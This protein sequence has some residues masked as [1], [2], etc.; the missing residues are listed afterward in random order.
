MIGLFGAGAVPAAASGAASLLAALAVALSWRAIEMRLLRRIYGAPELFQLLATF[1]VMLI[2]QDAALWIWGP[3]DLLG[4]R[5]PGTCG[6]HRILGSRFPSTTCCSSRSGQRARR[7]VWLAAD[8]TRWGV[9]VRAATE[10]RDMAA[11]L[12]V[13]Q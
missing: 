7:A 13:N 1:G 2:I 4:P 8:R 10:D 12:G 9:L 11:A 5:A 3:E 6:L